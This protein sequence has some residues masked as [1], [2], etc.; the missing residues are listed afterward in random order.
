MCSVTCRC[1][2]YEY[3]V[4]GVRIIKTSNEVGNCRQLKSDRFQEIWQK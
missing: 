1:S 3:S 2:V 4:D